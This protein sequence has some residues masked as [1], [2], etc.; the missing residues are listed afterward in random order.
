MDN[1]QEILTP[2]LL[3]T[4]ERHER[5][6]ALSKSRSKA[7]YE[8]NKAKILEKRRLSRLKEKQDLLEIQNRLAILN[9]QNEPNFEPNEPN[10]EPFDDL[11][12]E[13]IQ[14][15]PKTSNKK[16]DYTQQDLITIINDTDWK[17]NTKSTYISSIKRIFKAGGCDSL[18]NC[19]SDMKKFIDK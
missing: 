3:M 18:K 2:E 6:K 15:Q 4:K 11:E 10:F 8:K 13:I 5:S 9:I 16:Q 1:L 12:N 7:Y 14:P 17:K 19:L